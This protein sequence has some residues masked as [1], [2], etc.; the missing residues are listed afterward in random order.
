MPT[1]AYVIIAVA[2]AAAIVLAGAWMLLMR[3]RSNRL[4]ST[5]SSEYDRTVA[6]TG[7]RRRAEQ[8]LLE[9]EKRREQLKIRPLSPA[10]RERFADQWREAQAEFVDAPEEAVHDANALIEDAMSE[11][12][13]PVAD[14]EEQAAVIS[15]DYADVVQNYRSAHRIYVAAGEGEAS[16]EDLRRAMQHYRNLFEHLLGESVD[17]TASPSRRRESD[18]EEVRS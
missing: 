13:Y 17:T 5:F 11:R 1:W 2:A 15:V 16:T 14:F 7:G 18:R 9:R 6:E 3:R 12:G 4:R 8:D 10:S